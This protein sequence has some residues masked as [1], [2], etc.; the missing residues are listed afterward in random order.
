[1]ADGSSVKVLDWVGMD[2]K[3]GGY[4]RIVEAGIIYP[5]DKTDDA[6]DALA[7]EGECP[8]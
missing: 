1:M 6:G 4:Q 8:N 2:L 7:N 5:Y 3:C